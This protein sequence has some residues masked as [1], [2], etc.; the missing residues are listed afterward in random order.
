MT[1]AVLRLQKTLPETG[2]GAKTSP[3][4]TAFGPPDRPRNPHGNQCGIPEDDSARQ[5]CP[6]GPPERMPA[7]LR[8]QRTPPKTHFGI[9]TSPPR[10]AFGPQERPRNS[11][12]DHFGTQEGNNAQQ[13]CPKRPPRRPFPQDASNHTVFTSVMIKN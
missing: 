13:A 11:P 5:A 9:K 6:M 1:P 7:T 4:R 3:P 12:G 8:H 10:T 2:S